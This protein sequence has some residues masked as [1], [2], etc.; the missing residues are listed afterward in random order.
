MNNSFENDKKAVNISENDSALHPEHDVEVKE[1]KNSAKSEAMVNEVPLRTENT[2][3]Y[4][5]DGDFE[6]EDEE[7]CD[8]ECECEDEDEDEKS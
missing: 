2:T 1:T 5:D 6:D 3:D 7:E 8:E 4:E